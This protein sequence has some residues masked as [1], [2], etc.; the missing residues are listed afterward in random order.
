MIFP[1]C[2]MRVKIE[3]SKHRI[4]LWMP[5]FLVWIIL[6]IPAL[7]LLIIFFVLVLVLWYVEWVRVLLKGGLAFYGVL[8]SLRD[9]KVDVNRGNEKLLFYFK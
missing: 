8:C 6:G 5:L 1:P 2:L 3:N 7:A 4:N 9:L